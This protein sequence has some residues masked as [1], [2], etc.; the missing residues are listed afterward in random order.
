VPLTFR[1]DAEKRA[2]LDAVAQAL[3]RDRSYLLNEA[4]DAFLGVHR[5]LIAQIHEGHRQ[6]DGRGPVPICRR[7]KECS[8]SRAG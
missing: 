2:E 8:E 3:N 5:W 4:V 6:A 7:S 1:L